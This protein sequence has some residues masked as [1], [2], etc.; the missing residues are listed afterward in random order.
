MIEESRPDDDLL[1]HGLRTIREA[2]DYTRLSRATLYSL[3]DKG[4]LV[5]TTIGRRRLI[6]YQA[7]VELAARK[8]V[9]R[10]QL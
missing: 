7:L 2:Q 1:R 6:P 3:M 9:G 8:L 10:P 5:Y 4:E